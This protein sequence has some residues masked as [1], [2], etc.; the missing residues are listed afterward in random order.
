MLTESLKRQ[1]TNAFAVLEAAIPSFREDVWRRGKS[2]FDGP[3]RATA[4][5]LQCGEF[6]T[7]RDRAVL[8][9]LGKKKIWEMSDD[10]MPSQESMLRYLSQVRDKTMAWLDGIGDA[11]LATPMPDVH[12]ATTLEWV[13]YALRH[14]Q[15]H[16]GEICAYQKQA[17]LPPAPWK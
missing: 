2:P 16:T 13:V 9:N 11:G 15:H 6:Y 4:H 17:G 5:A 1:F 7:C 10:E 3:A 12:A 8:E 14:F